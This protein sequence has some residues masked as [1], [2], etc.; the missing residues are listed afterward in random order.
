MRATWLGRATDKETGRKLDLTLT[1]SDIVIDESRPPRPGMNQSGI[2]SKN[3][4]YVYSNALDNI[5]LE[6]IAHAK[7]TYSYRY[8]DTL[9][10]YDKPYYITI[11]S[12]DWSQ[13]RD[14]DKTSEIL[15]EYTAPGKNVHASFLGNGSYIGSDMQTVYGPAS[16]KLN[17]NI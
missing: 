8:S 10:P 14:G 3:R 12:L 16:D 2:S 1:I 7:K 11:G 15:A 5:S 6:N 9:E 17:I 13:I 4:L